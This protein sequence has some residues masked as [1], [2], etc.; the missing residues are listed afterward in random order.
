M[1]TQP[2]EL[3]KLTS[4]QA[5]LSRALSCLKTDYETT[6]A[7]QTA[8]FTLSAIKQSHVFNYTLELNINNAPA[9]IELDAHAVNS[10]L[11]EQ[12]NHDVISVLP[13]ELLM[14]VLHYRIVPIAQQTAQFIDMPIEVLGLRPSSTGSVDMG[15]LI[16]ANIANIN[17]SALIDNS[18]VIFSLFNALPRAYN[19]AMQNIPVRAGIE[20]G[21]SLLSTKEIKELETGDIIFLQQ[22]VTGNQII[23]RLNPH[24]AFIAEMDGEQVTI[25]QRIITM[26]DEL[27]EHEEGVDLADLSVEL[28]FEIGR[29]QFNASDLTGLNP[30]F[31]FELDRPIE[32]PVRIRANGKVIAECQLVQIENRLGAKITQLNKT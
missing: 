14:A 7:G 10:F 23:I 15:L 13:D 29:Q 18:D 27:N 22:H 5:K 20:L 19:P 8:R 11:P 16:S 12:L 21:R 26:D 3:I 28:L 9:T 25:Q 17:C 2:L 24:I 6:I 1:S 32:Q 30:G 31:V 4:E